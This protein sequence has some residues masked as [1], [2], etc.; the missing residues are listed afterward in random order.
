M[1]DQDLEDI[2]DYISRDN[3]AAALEVV[4]NIVN[5]V[6]VLGNNP[7]LGRVVPEFQQQDLREIVHSHY[8]IIYRL[9][10]VIQNIE[11]IRIWHGARGYP[12]IG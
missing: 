1:A 2:F 6:K 5:Q 7:Y 11:I 12:K 9:H 10:E 4:G 3:H 8:R